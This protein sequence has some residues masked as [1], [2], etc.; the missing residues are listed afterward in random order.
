MS[1]ILTLTLP[2]TLNPDPDPDPNPNLG[3]DVPRQFARPLLFRSTG[4]DR[5]PLTQPGR[6][7]NHVD[8]AEVAALV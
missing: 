1:E 4:R 5:H 3:G 2:L 7:V 6:S 8:R